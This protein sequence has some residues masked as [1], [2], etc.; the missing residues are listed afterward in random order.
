MQT[1]HR[2]IGLPG[3]K[4]SF[5]MVFLSTAPQ[6]AHSAGC[7]MGVAPLAFEDPRVLSVELVLQLISI[8]HALE[9]LS[10]SR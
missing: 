5:S 1:N 9:Q 4:S 3:Y 2:L 6:T 7:A 8:T 10:Y